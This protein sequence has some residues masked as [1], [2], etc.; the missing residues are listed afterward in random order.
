MTFASM[1]PRDHDKEK[2][3][4]NP[5]LL[6]TGYQY[7]KPIRGTDICRGRL[8]NHSSNELSPEKVVNLGQSSALINLFNF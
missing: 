4:P 2:E 5:D 7:R 6:G 8:K 3:N 1:T